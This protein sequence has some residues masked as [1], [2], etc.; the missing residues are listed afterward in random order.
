MEAGIH[1]DVR[2]NDSQMSKRQSSR[3]GICSVWSFCDQRQHTS[4]RWASRSSENRASCRHCLLLNSRTCRSRT[5][6]VVRPSSEVR[7]GLVDF[8]SFWCPACLLSS[9]CRSGSWNSR[10]QSMLADLS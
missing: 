5:T 7:I 1:N 8:L 9:K 2:R 3:V 4:F 6:P 10:Q